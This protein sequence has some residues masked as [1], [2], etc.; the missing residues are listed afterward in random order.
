MEDKKSL[1]DIYQQIRE[2]QKSRYIVFNVMTIATHT[3]AHILTGNHTH[4][5]MH[6]QYKINY[7]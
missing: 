3:H 6:R 7:I 4:T 2:V 5:H 1:G